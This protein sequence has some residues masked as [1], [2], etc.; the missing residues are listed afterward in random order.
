MKEIT[1]QNIISGHGISISI[2]GMAIVFSGLLIITICISLLPRILE[3]PD[4]IRARSIKK[5]TPEERIPEAS[6]SEATA[7]STT[8]ASDQ[9]PATDDENDIASV[10]A[11]VLQLE[12]ERYFRWDSETITI[13]REAGQPSMWGKTNKMR[14]V[15]HRRTYAKV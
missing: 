7:E 12:S 11:L 5:A 9:L 15:P 10:I 3:L 13:N 2:T 8:P 6:P 4:K 14:P 1:L